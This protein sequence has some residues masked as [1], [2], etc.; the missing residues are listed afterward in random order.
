MR[1]ASFSNA[2]ARVIL[3]VAFIFGLAMLAISFGSPESVTVL[4]QTGDNPLPRPELIV[5]DGTNG[6]D[7]LIVTATGPNAGSY[8]LND[9]AARGTIA[10][11][12]SF[13]FNGSG[14]NDTFTIINPADGL[15]DPLDGID[16]NGGGQAGDNMNLL[17]GTAT[18]ETYFVGTTAPPIG[19]GPGNNGD[20]LIRFTGPDLDIRFTGL[21]PIVDTVV[22]ASLTV[23][24]TDAANTIS[25][26]NGAVAPRLRVAVDA[27]EPIDFDNK[28]QVFVNGG[29]GTAL[30]DVG[31]NIT[32]NYSNTPAALAG[33]SVSGNEGN[34]T[35]TVLTRSGA[36]PLNLSGNENDDQLN[37][38]ATVFGPGSIALNGGDGNDALIGGGD[39]DQFDGGAGN[40]TFIGNG[41]TD[42][43]GAGAGV[44]VDDRLLVPGTAAGDTITLAVNGSDFL[45][46]TIN[47]VTTT[48]RNFLGGS[49][50]TSGIEA[51]VVDADAGNDTVTV[52]SRTGSYNINLNGNDDNDTL[53]AGATLAGSGV[54]Q[55]N[56]GAGND[57]LIGGGDDDQF[58]GGAGNDTFI[59]NGGI[60]N[61]GGGAGTS[62]DDRLLVFGTLAGDTITLAVNGSDHLVATTNGVTTTYRNFLGGPFASSGIETVV[63]NTDAGNDTINIA[64]LTNS[65]INIDGGSPV[66]PTQP[67]D[68]LTAD[69]TGATGT[70]F[71]PGVPGSGVVTFTNRSPVSYTS[72]ETSPFQ[73]S[74]GGN[75]DGVTAPALPGGW[76]STATG[77]ETAWVTSTTTPNTAPN[78][79]FAPDVSTVG[80]T[81]LVSPTIAVPAG[82][83]Q[84]TFSNLFNMEFQTASVGFDGMVLEIS[85]NGGAFADIVTAGG[86]F[87]TGGYTHTIS[88]GFS[89]PIAG[90]LAW[91]GLSAGTTA[92]PA[93][94]T[95]TVNLPAAANG[96]NAR[97]RWRVATDTSAVAAGVPGVR[98]DTISG[99]PCTSITGTVTY[100]NAIGS[101]APPRFVSNVLVSGAGSVAVSTTTGG[102]GV[103]AGQYSLTG[104]G[105]GAYTVTPTKTGGV[106]GAITSF[107]AG[108]IA[109]HVGGPPNPQLNATQLIVADV[110]GNGLVTSFDAGMIAK[111]VAGP[112]FTAPGIGSTATWRF[113]PVNR[114]Y[115]SVT[116]SVSGEDF[117]AVLMGEVSGNWTNSGARPAGVVESGELRVESADNSRVEKPI[118]VKVPQIVTR[119]KEIVVPVSVEGIANKDMI[120][121]E[122]DLRYDPSVMQPVGD[123]VDVRGT[124]SRGLSVVLNA[125]EP[126]LLRVVVYGAYPIDENG[127]LLNLRFASVGTSG[128]VSPISF[129]RIKFNEG[130][131]R[132]FVTDGK[133]E[134]F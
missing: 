57:A 32:V 108:R 61:I 121:Y 3:A 22:A 23:N 118:T 113:T 100:G 75:F 94:I 51:V 17:G 35:V 80:E 130:E 43:I 126:G 81:F 125:T 77:G 21:A 98:I 79:A 74:C 26:T 12:T 31:D 115:A 34:D 65:A 90:R 93:Y 109:L 58:D 49:F 27:F 54:I 41:G 102:V 20:G 48:Y 122:F 5:V 38:G 86:S 62:L 60:D 45:V 2:N 97:L 30:G 56:G 99:L 83:A 47:G 16:F 52:L 96:Q 11:V 33:L 14:G 10:G 64:P 4:A 129:E 84:I 40:D 37:A 69:L 59:G 24:S 112:P 92:A 104:F 128:S 76:S 46:A 25:V 101:P 42:N 110:S 124:V 67:G 123:A 53:D 111:Y 44:S 9:G 50:A 117:V 1:K 103:T 105:A 82:G 36:Y 78:D 63:V 133:I 39:D 88:S 66:L 95:T 127:V 7:T 28:T 71:A 91:S 87:V 131:V 116:S 8:S 119:D 132:V 70:S 73:V 15:F 106:N 134:L 18:T 72:I 85:I 114:N 89:S 55:L 19:V 120:S 29:D 13:I 68:T 6:D 107:D